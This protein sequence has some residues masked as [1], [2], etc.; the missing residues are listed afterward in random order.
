MMLSCGSK[1]GDSNTGD[2]KF[3]S[4][5]VNRTEH[6]MA[7]TAKPA[8]NLIINIVYPKSSSDEILTDSLTYHIV[9]TCLGDQYAGLSAA[10][11]VNQYTKDYVGNYLADITPLYE[12]DHKGAPDNTVSDSWY[13][14]YRNMEGRVQ[15]YEKSLLVYRF[16]Y[17]EYTGGAHGMRAAIYINIDL[18]RKC[19]LTLDDVFAGDYKEALTDLIWNQL[20]A[21]NNAATRE[22]LEEMGYGSTGEIAP[23]ENFYLNHEGITFFYNAYDITPY[24]M[25]STAVSIPFDLLERWLNTTPIIEELR[26][27]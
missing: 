17:D 16:Y 12:E 19:P 11:A 18:N 10:E 7:D 15:L 8:C 6:L 20:M 2:I 1:T 21:D 3:D 26:N 4:I 24:A 23:T 5:S 13:S 9:N 27:E 22:E 25:G 14:Y